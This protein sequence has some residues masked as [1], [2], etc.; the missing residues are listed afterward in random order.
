VEFSLL[1]NVSSPH[2]LFV[3]SL[4]PDTYRKFATALK[5]GKFG[6]EI[7]KTFFVGIL[8]FSPSCDSFAFGHSF[9]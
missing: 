5:T 1:Q 7:V 2:T 8:C 3:H 9:E 6:F 4:A